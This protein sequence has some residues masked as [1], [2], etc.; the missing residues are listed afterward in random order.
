VILLD[1]HVL[2][3]LLLGDARLKVPV[4]R[5]ISSAEIVGVA[6]IT[7]WEIATLVRLGRL[8]AV[9]PAAGWRSAVLALGIVDV[10]IDADIAW[11][12]GALDDVRG[13]PADRLIMATAE[14]QATPLVTADRAILRHRARLSLIDAR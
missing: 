3:W 2:L 9:E 1:T 12:A 14:A 8:R 6:A 5:R 11:R 7:F 10:P 4:R 13:D